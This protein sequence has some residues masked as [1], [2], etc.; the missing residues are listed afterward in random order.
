MWLAF[1]RGKLLRGNVFF[2]PKAKSSANGAVS[3]SVGQRPTNPEKK[4][5]SPVRAK[6]GVPARER[7]ALFQSLI[8]N[9]SQT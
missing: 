1:P 6:A 9:T 2:S 7:L 5:L 8:I 4:I 3:N